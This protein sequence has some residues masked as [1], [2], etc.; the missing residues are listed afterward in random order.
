MLGTKKGNVY[1]NTGNKQ[2]CLYIQLYTLLTYGWTIPATVNKND[3]TSHTSTLLTV[4]GRRNN[5]NPSSYVR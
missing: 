1:I 3:E 4:V 2:S 5:N